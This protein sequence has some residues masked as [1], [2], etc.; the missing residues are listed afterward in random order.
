[1]TMYATQASCCKCNDSITSLSASEFEKKIKTGSMQLLD[2]RTPQEYDEAHID[3]AININVQSD[4]F[5]NIAEK[6]LSKGS[7]I[8]I[9]CRSG[10]RSMDAADILTKSGYKII[11]LK[12]GII[13]WKDEGFPVIST[14]LS[15]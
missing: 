3:K 7:T 4:D 11:N 9:Y 14:D 12:G 13:E 5:Q 2:V 1:M 6:K 15:K 10:R 8:L